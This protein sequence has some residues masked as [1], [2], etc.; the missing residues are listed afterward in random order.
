VFAGKR[1]QQGDKIENYR[2]FLLCPLLQKIHSYMRKLPVAGEST[3]LMIIVNTG[4]ERD[5]LHPVK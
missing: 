3:M 1:C 5:G 4:L 2:R